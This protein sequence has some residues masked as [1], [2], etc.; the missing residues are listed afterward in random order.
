MLQTIRDRLTGPIIWVVVIL[1]V[2]PFAFWGIQ[3]FR[4]GGTD[5]T[6]AEVAGI[7]ITQSQFRREYEQQYQQFAQMM[8]EHFNPEMLNTPRFRKG[9]LDRMIED[10]ALREYAH[11]AGYRTADAQ[12]LDQIRA[13]PAFQKDGAFS[14]DAYR[15]ALAARG[16]TPEGFEAQV[17]NGLTTEQLREALT[18]SAFVGA[19]SVTVQRTVEHEKRSFDYA[20]IEP[21]KFLAQVQV[22]DAQTHAE[23]DAHKDRY[24]SPERVKLAYVELAL[25]KLPKPA[26]PSADV[27]KAVYEAQKST[28]FS[29]PE[30]RHAQHILITF[31]A[32]KEAARKKTAE[33]VAK[34]RQG[35]DFAAVAKA[36]SDD[37]GSK[38]AGGDLGW[39]RH[40]MMVPAFENALFA[41]KAGEISDPVES[42]YGWHIIKLDEVRPA[43]VK[44][45]E[46]AD[47]QKQLTEEF[48][49]K[50]AAQRFQDAADKLEQLAFENPSSLDPVAKALDLTVQ[51]TDWL[52]RTTT[53][54]IAKTPAVRDAAFSASVLNDG[55]NSKPLQ[56]GPD[57]L[58]VIRKLARE[59]P[60]QLSFDEVSAQVR[61]QLRNDG[62]KA[63]AAAA[64]DALEA[65]LKQ[66]QAIDAAAKAQG[67]TVTP[68]N[69][70]ERMQ[71]GID[72]ALLTEVFKLPRPAAGAASVG[73]ASLPQDATAV[74]ALR[75]VK[76]PDAVP[77]DDPD[78]RRIAAN[79]RDSEG[80]AEFEAYLAALQDKL[81]VK[82][83]ADP[84]QVQGGA[85]TE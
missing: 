22:T 61:D 49:K 51:T 70:A 25:D 71:Q 38:T 18:G 47:V 4:G 81:G 23:Y 9:V 39:V 54:G 13:I 72:A 29:T 3:S 36:E 65:A 69:D 37:P 82:V 26:T 21:A 80:G 7:K 15:Q 59:A 35:G 79:L 34:L 55:E 8:G 83:I 20:R 73:R 43:K 10:T 1:I 66:G 2:V 14:A 44:P 57:T 67:L 31:G 6:V 17:R 84:S 56:A 78:S 27:L 76:A 85:S 62:A 46:E 53:D 77:A 33:L 52:T 32:D 50:D 41:M 45:F 40:G 75:S 48:Q 68:V 11:D 64:A 19:G 12:L 5:P 30:E 74:I 60:R 24:Q 16:Q 63:K 42:P 58:I 28:R